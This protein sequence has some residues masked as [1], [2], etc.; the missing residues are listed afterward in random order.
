MILNL[1]V[2]LT[3]FMSTRPSFMLDPIPVPQS[4][5]NIAR[6]LSR[7]AGSYKCKLPVITSAARSKRSSSALANSMQLAQDKMPHIMVKNKDISEIATPAK[8]KSPSTSN[9]L[10][11]LSS[12]PLSVRKRL[13]SAYK[14]QICLCLLP[15]LH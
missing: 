9:P 4:S 7:G 14:D 10:H 13:L 15:V 5:P 2:N 12:T 3:T 8:S 1:S 6:P 11:S